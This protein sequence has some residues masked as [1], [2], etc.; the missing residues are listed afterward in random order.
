MRP[1]Q[2]NKEVNIFERR[3]AVNWVSMLTLT[4]MGPTMMDITL[5]LPEMQNFLNQNE[6]FDAIFGEIFLDESLLAGLSYKYNA[7]LIGLA[8]FM[9]NYWS[10]YMVI[11]IC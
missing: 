9:P 11:I 10:N 5:S 1:G 4:M 6:K 7:P 8:T 2:E 3:T